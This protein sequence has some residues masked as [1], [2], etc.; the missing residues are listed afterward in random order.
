MLPVLD[1]LGWKGGKRAFLN[2]LPYDFRDFDTHDMM[3]TMAN[4]GFRVKPASGKLNKLDTRLLPCLFIDRKNQAYVLLS[5]ENDGYFCYSGETGNFEILDLGWKTGEFYF[6]ED[7]SESSRNPEKEQKDWFSIFFT[8]FRK[9][10]VVSLVLSFLL[11]LTALAAPF[12][13]MGI[14]SQINSAE[15]MTGFWIIGAGILG[16]L[17]V[18]LFFR[19]IR[20]WILGFLGAR[21]GF[22][23]STQVF[24]RILSFNPSA[25]ENASVGSQIVRMRDFNSVRSF[26]EG[27][28]MTSVMDLPFL[29][30][31]FIGLIIMA[32]SLALIPVTA[33]MVLVI[34]SFSILPFV[35]KN[36]LEAADSAGKKQ[37]Y[38][39][40][41]FSEF[42]AIRMS[43]LSLKWKDKYE[44]LSANAAVDVL[45]TANINSVINNVSQGVVSIAG[46]VTITL[47]VFGV[48]NGRFS[49]AILIAAMMLVWK[50]LSPV[51][52]G[53]SVFSQTIRIKKSLQ[54]LNRLMTMKLEA[55]DVNIPPVQFNGRIR[56]KGVSL[57]YK[58]DYYP[59]LLGV[60]LRVEKGQFVVINGH[61]GAGKSTLLK[62]I[63]GMYKA[64]AGTIMLDETNIQ[65]LAPAM[66]RRSVAYLPQ[67]EVLFNI[68]I[69]KNMKYASPTSSREKI[70]SVLEK[71]GVDK[72]LKNLPD[73][74]ETSVA[75][76]EGVPD[77]SSIKKSLCIAR[78]LLNDSQIVLL[79]EPDRGIGKKYLPGLM[80]TL[81]EL[82]ALNKT[83]LVASNHPDFIKFADTVVTFNLGTIINIETYPVQ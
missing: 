68:S 78:T 32:G 77:A 10:L 9:P 36:N 6:F 1:A 20:H 30:I 40:E 27:P 4:L 71:L 25:T 35:K 70:V 44:Q 29:V 53:F 13:V 69:E 7:L 18:D 3:N 24:K 83:V 80:N 23:V 76:L 43:G 62:L 39:I 81:A 38:L 47:G 51:S 41:F 45:R 52:S 34:F 8:R 63:L 58:P 37:S 66:L 60:D 55:T 57:R 17:M 12:I 42:R 22:L 46:A 31:L 49:G 64:Q 50:I 11:A 54:Q 74:L 82:K 28:G 79:D 59:A 21:M 65:Q 2:A 73:Y 56:F 61:D 72:D 67:E 19:L 33:A 48:L 16:I 75:Q 15:S 26:V 14:Y 5:L